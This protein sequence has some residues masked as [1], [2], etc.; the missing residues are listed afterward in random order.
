MK[1][2]VM[3]WIY[4]DEPLEKTLE[5]LSRLGYDGISLKGEPDQYD[6]EATKQLV[7]RYGLEVASIDGIYPWPTDERDLSNPEERVRKRAVE[8]VNR[9][10]DLA[11][12][13]GA[14]LVVVV[15]SPVGKTKS[16][17]TKQKEW[18]WAVESVK[19]VAEYALQKGIEVA[20]EPINRYE[21][22]LLN[23]C[24]QAL[25]F[26]KE[27]AV[28]NTK[29]ML[30]CFHMNIEEADP[31]AAVR[32]AGRMLI[33]MHVADSN[34]QSVG[35]GHTD[36]KAIMRSLKEIGYER[37]LA[38]EPLPPLADPYDALTKQV[39]PELFDVYAKECID[40]LKAIERVL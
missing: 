17:A 4:G 6:P 2:S 21:T 40:N 28:E 7:R 16:L 26:V 8:Y 11:V 25:E 39:C 19:R 3:N 5:R 24:E 29:I 38:M 23:N 37:Y 27:V 1:Y 32:R 13:V 10:T 20:V 9:C 31:A 22:H 36:F 12:A 15:P 33:H 30:D 14:P 18:E 35:R 34:R